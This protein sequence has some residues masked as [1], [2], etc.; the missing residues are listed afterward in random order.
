MF[1]FSIM[2]LKTEY[3]EHYRNAERPRKIQFN[4]MYGL[5]FR[6]CAVFITD[7]V[8]KTLKRSDLTMNFILESG[9]KNAGDAERVFNEL[10]KEDAYKSMFKSITFGAKEDYFGLQGADYVSHT[11]F[12]AE[13]GNP[14]LTEFPAGGN[15]LDAK[16]LLSHKSPVFRCH[17]YPDLLKDI[18]RKMMGLDAKRMEFGKCKTITPAPARVSQ[19]AE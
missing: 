19:A 11:A 1:G 13:Q 4:S 12:L 3:L 15:M 16:K 2:L 7:L 9:A 14:E 17:I 10:K 18:K 8:Q 6:F 5:C